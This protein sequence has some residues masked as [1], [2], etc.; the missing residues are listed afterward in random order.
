VRTLAR[1]T[2]P[3]QAQGKGL[4]LFSGNPSEGDT[5]CAVARISPSRDSM[6]PLTFTFLPAT[7][8]SSVLTMMNCAPRGRHQRSGRHQNNLKNKN[9]SGTHLISF[10]R[11]LVLHIQGSGNADLGWNVQ[12][13][14][15][16]STDEPD[17]SGISS[18]SGTHITSQTLVQN[19][20]QQTSVDDAIMPAQ[21]S[22]DMEDDDG[23]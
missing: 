13:C 4:R 17:Q 21:A 1:R 18:C 2:A 22:S 20:R 12:Q 15:R 9:L 7:A 10:C 16:E 8:S 23:R 19:R 5:Y 3:C 14:L 11:L 6:L